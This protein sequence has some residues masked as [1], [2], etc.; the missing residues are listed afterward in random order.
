MPR[1]IPYGRLGQIVIGAVAGIAVVATL[2]GCRRDDRP[3]APTRQQASQ[4][5]DAEAMLNAV[6]GVNAADRASVNRAAR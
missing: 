2:G 6:D 5:D 1:I 3:A 4:L